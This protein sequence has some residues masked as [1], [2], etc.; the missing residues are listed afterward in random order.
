M[1]GGGHSVK[2]L[3]RALLELLEEITLAVT[4]G[5][6]SSEPYPYPR[7]NHLRQA[8]TK[9]ASISWTSTKPEKAPFVRSMTGAEVMR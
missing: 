7:T 3:D 9:M 6:S 8:R 1:D 5:L 2:D 4:G